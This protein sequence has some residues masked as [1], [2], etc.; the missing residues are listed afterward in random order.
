MAIAKTRAEN[1]KHLGMP[2]D[3]DVPK[4]TKQ[5]TME[6]WKFSERAANDKI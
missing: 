6:I 4:I 3:K 5:D 1:I 2:E